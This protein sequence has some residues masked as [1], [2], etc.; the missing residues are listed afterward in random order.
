V[1][2]AAASELIDVAYEFL[3]AQRASDLIDADSIL[4]ALDEASQPARVARFIARFVQPGRARLFERAR[5]SALKLGVWLPDPVR[6][7]IASHLGQPVHLPRALVEELVASERV[8]DG[9]RATLQEAMS[10]V[11]ER[12][13]AAAP[14]GS[15]RGLRGMIGLAGAAGRG[16]FGGLGEEVQRQL[17]ERLKDLV[18][19]AVQL[20]QKRIVERL[21]AEETAHQLGLRRRAVFLKLL[22][23]D[24]RRAARFVE[25]APWQLLDALAPALVSHN[26]ARAEV[27]AAVR[28]EVEAVLTELST[29]TLGELVDELGLRE[30]VRAALHRHGAPLVQ[31]LAATPGFA[32]WRTKWP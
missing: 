31:R 25:Q 1:D 29:Q 26:L 3:L 27:R 15:G 9:V 12:A 4:A 7:A 30:V 14:A 10:G 20:V 13:F 8:R 24:E 21:T 11:I 5:A 2:A 17:Q 22:D 16:L 23:E 18:D 28:A 6:D 32:A 19:S